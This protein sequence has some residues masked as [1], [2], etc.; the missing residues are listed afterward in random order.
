[1]YSYVCTYL[2]TT[3]LHCDFKPF[4]CVGVAFTCPN[5][6]TFFI[7]WVRDERAES[8]YYGDFTALDLDLHLDLVKTVLI[9]VFTKGYCFRNF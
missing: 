1:M 9:V 8:H 6:G 5:L 7:A 3:S 2:L 4:I